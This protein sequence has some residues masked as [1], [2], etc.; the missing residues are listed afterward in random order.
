MRFAALA[1]L[2][3]PLTCLA[4]TITLTAPPVAV[5]A[6]A[7]GALVTRSVSFDIPAGQHSLRIADMDPDI[8]IEAT[9]IALSGATILSRQWSDLDS[10][11]YRAPRTPAWQ[12]AKARV[13]AATQ[14]LAQR[15]D[16]IALALA[17]GQAAQDQI[18]FLNGIALPEDAATN[19]DTLRAIGQL[20]ASDGTAARGAIRAADAE[21]RALRRGRDDLVFELR[22]AEAAL[23]DATPPNDAPMVLTL[24]VEAAAA[25]P[26]TLDVRYVTPD[27]EWEPIYALS[28]INDDTLTI[29]RGA[30]VA[31]SSG[32]HW[33]DVSLT[34][35]TLSPFEGSNPGRLRAQR[36]R[37]EDPAQAPVAPTRMRTLGA[38]ADSQLAEPIIEAPIIVEE[39]GRQ[40]A[41]SDFSGVGVSYTL[42]GLVDVPAGRAEVEIALDTLTFDAAMTARAVP[43]MDATAYRLVV[44]ENTSQDILLPGEAVLFVNDQLVGTTFMDALPPNAEADIFFG[45]IEGLRLTRTVLDRNEGDRG[46]I[47]RSNEQ[48]EE[49]RIDIENLTDRDWDVSLRDSVPFSEQDDLVIT[50]TAN[51]APDEVAIDDRRGILEWDLALQA[52][53]SQSISV[54]TELRWPEGMILR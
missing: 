38:A 30:V 4:D 24:N 28:L 19:V 2:F 25:G 42:P 12:E 18:Q 27:V 48:R 6:Y 15:D 10:T 51:P 52:G 47:N 16:Q 26:A 39:M 41:G 17:K 29:D 36:R 5:T 23:V 7:S 45:P 54:E 35:S 1:L 21:A 49:V 40:F 44:F 20:I 34:L 9:D 31:Q 50:W 13:D 43:L 8:V 32:E 3:C 22:V 33:N 11:L 46:L 37:I 14:A 53:E